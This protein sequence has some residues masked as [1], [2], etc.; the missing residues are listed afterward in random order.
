MKLDGPAMVVRLQDGHVD[1]RPEDQ[2]EISAKGE[3]KAEGVVIRGM[4]S[5][6]LTMLGVLLGIALTVAFGVPDVEWYSRVLLGVATFFG[7]ATLAH[8]GFSRVLVRLA[9]GVMSFARWVLGGRR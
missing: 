9:H 6:R 8:L 7:I 4:N 3:L 5:D 1:V 2:L